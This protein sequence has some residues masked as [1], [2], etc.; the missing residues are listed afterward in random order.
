M[1]LITSAKYL[2]IGSKPFSKTAPRFSFKSPIAFFNCLLLSAVA[3]ASPLYFCPK[4]ST[5]FPLFNSSSVSVF[6]S[7]FCCP[8]LPIFPFK[9]AFNCDTAFSKEIVPVEAIS[10]ATL[11]ICIVSVSVLPFAIKSDIIGNNCSSPISETF[12][13]SEAKFFNRIEAVP[14]TSGLF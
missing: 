12:C 11:I 8:S 3:C 7:A 14:S 10:V 2:R 9:V 5:A 1:L 6:N 13:I 4:I